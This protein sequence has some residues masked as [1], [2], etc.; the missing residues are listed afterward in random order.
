MIALYDLGKVTAD[1]FFQGYS[2][3]IW[4]V[5]LLQVGTLFST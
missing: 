4:I 5:V 2:T 1:G 3:V